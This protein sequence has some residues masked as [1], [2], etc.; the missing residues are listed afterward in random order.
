MTKQARY[1][2]RC[3]EVL[4]EFHFVHT[5]VRMNLHLIY[6]SHFSGSPCWDMSCRAFQMM[7]AT[8]NR[9]IKITFE[10]PYQTHRNLL[11]VLSS[12]KPLRV[13]LSRRLLKFVDCIRKSKK[14]VLKNILR[15]VECDVRTVTGGNL[16]S[17]LMLTDTPCVESLRPADIDNVSYSGQLT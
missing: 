3:S 9:N 13:L 1:K 7:E 15:R 4:Q 8:Y 17:I 10:L 12:V 6:N 14:V 5:Y 16:R 2:Q 11:P